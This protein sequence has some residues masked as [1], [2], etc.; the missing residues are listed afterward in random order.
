M[1]DCDPPVSKTLPVCTF[2]RKLPLGSKTKLL[3]FFT[4]TQIYLWVLELLPMNFGAFYTLYD[5]G[6]ACAVHKSIHKV[7]ACQVLERLQ[8]SGWQLDMREFCFS[9]KDAED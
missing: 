3:L 5:L 9:K 8:K 1:P 4:P 7:V 2:G 6:T